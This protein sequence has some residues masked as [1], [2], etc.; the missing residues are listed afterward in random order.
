[1]R[2][3]S[4]AVDSFFKLGSKRRENDTP[5]T[6]W[7]TFLSL[8]LFLYA[9]LTRCSFIWQSLSREEEIERER[10]REKR[11]VKRKRNEEG[12]NNERIYFDRI[13]SVR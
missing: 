7:V 9:C 8:S 2:A 11:E 12:E 3:F 6:D 5:L 10:E 1:M 4:F 13:C